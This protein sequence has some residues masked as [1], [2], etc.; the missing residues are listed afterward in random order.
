MPCLRAL[1]VCGSKPPQQLPCAGVEM[2]AIV[3]PL[4]SWMALAP[5]HLKVPDARGV[6][7]ILQQ[8]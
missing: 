7:L 6:Q 3:W 5:E 2:G 8:I 4:C 1:C